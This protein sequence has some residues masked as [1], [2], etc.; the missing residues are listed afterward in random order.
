MLAQA[1]AN[2][3]EAPFIFKVRYAHHTDVSVTKWCN[4][5]QHGDI[6]GMLLVKN[7]IFSAQ[8][9]PTF[10]ETIGH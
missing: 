9:K 3:E 8:P 7:A 1:P 2:I 4:V 5:A 10:Q 6:I